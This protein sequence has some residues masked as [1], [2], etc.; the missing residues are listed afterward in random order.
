MRSSQNSGEEFLNW[1]Y[2]FLCILGLL[3]A[4]QWLD[5]TGQ[6]SQCKLN[7]EAVI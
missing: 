5:I 6:V 2:A 1:S 4:N 7:P 3:K